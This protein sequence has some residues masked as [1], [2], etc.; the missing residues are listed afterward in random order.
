M[1]QKSHPWA[2]RPFVELCSRQALRLLKPAFVKTLIHE[3]D[4]APLQN[5][6][7][8]VCFADGSVGVFVLEAFRNED[9]TLALFD[10]LQA[11]S[12]RLANPGLY[13]LPPA[14]FLTVAQGDG[15]SPRA[16][17]EPGARDV[18][19]GAL[20]A[21][22]TEVIEWAAA[23]QASDIHLNVQRHLGES[24]IWFT[25]AGRYVRPERYAHIPTATMLDM[26][27]VTWMEV[28]GGNGAVF[29]PS[30]EQEGRFVRVCNGRR[31]VIRWA[32]LAT[33]VGPSVC[34]RLL[35]L[36]SGLSFPTFSDLG[37][38][39]S[40][41]EALEGARLSQGGAIILAGTV[42]S[43]KSTTIA[44]LLRN[45]P[46]HR[47]V[48]TLEDPAEYAIPNAL[49]NTVTR[50]I[51]DEGLTAFDRKL[52]AIK[53]SAMSDLLIGEIRDQAAGRAFVDL[54]A[55]GVS[56]Y[57]TVHAGSALLIPERLCSSFIGIPRDFL[58]APG[59]LKL[60][61]Y[62]ALLRELCPHCALNFEQFLR[63]NVLSCVRNIDRS[64]SWWRTWAS[65]VECT[66]GI[67]STMLRFCNAVGCAH[68]QNDIPMTAGTK[69][70]TVVAEM[71]SIARD[72]E[73]FSLLGRGDQSAV[74]RSL[75]ARTKTPFT[76]AEMQGKSAFECGL[77]KMS[78][79]QIDPREIETHFG[80]FQTTSSRRSTGA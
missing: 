33:D 64:A 2:Q 14:L 20:S 31:Y 21:V 5:R 76:D 59:V 72:A 42:G 23:K 27:A 7:Y 28:Q 60:L 1:T 9:Q 26:L 10:L 19:S 62:Q 38:L 11:K 24:S 51:H 49:Q 52:K 56:L 68:C 45:I 32:S 67:P 66:F 80:L 75:L 39:P 70:R 13:V 46:S 63:T 15:L 6:M 74:H 17:N 18:L 22:M 3:F 73:I 36:D 40:Q 34:L 4:V 25:I 37:Y 55:T 29:D 43:G 77:Y 53:R 30:V 41:I 58:T 8:P 65:S 12:R 71:L 47:K 57:T 61:V 79:G 50:S 78:T 54:A 48:I 69:G 44:S 35:R 16:V